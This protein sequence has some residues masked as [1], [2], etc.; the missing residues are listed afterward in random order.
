MFSGMFHLDYIWFVKLCDPLVNLNIQII[1]FCV[2]LFGF[3]LSIFW[4]TFTGL[5][6]I[7]FRRKAFETDMLWHIFVLALWWCYMDK[8]LQIHLQDKEHKNWNWL[9]EIADFQWA[10]TV[11]VCM[12]SFNH[13]WGEKKKKKVQNDSSASN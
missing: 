6:L 11:F 5:N 9:S 13:N 10:R 8:N 12:F 4:W 7:P 3:F 1:L 2:C